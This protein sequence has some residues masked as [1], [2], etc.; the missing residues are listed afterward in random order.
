MGQTVILAIV[1]GTMAVVSGRRTAL[2]FAIG[3]YWASSNLVLLRTVVGMS[4]EVIGGENVPPGPCIF[5]SKHQSDWDIFALLPFTA[6]PAFIAKK[7][8]T[9]IPFFGWAATSIDTIEIDRALG[10]EAIPQMIE[11]ARAALARG[12][13]I[14]IFPEGTRK[15]PLEPPDYRQGIVR[16]YEALGVP[17][18]P[19]AL[20][21]GLCWERNSLII[22]PGTATASIL[23]PIPPGLD[24]ETFRSRL[25]T[26]IEIETDA[27]ILTAVGRGLRRPIPARWRDRLAA[28][29][30]GAL[31]TT[32]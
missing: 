29:Q 1:V 21:S 28:L 11:N 18:V 4:T 19:V 15:K 5:A 24:T 2:G 6:R 10:A 20:N 17:V 8:L 31:P 32:H 16:L 27:L 3:K 14:I 25:Q 9:R 12:C 26:V 13:Q 22:W 30:S 23:P 7:E